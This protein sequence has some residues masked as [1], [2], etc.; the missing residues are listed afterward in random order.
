MSYRIIGKVADDAARIEVSA[1]N[2]GRG[3]ETVV[4]V[5]AYRGAQIGERSVGMSAK[6]A[7]AVALLLTQ[8]ASSL[9]G[10]GAPQ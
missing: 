7:Q 9:A 4:Y 2:G 6:M 10:K 8:A 1:W 5:T 3:R